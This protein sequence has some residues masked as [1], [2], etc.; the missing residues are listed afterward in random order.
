[1]FEKS[2]GMRMWNGS[3]PTVILIGSVC[4]ISKQKIKPEKAEKSQIAAGS[5]FASMSCA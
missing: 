5:D 2:W 1:M 4:D 3:K